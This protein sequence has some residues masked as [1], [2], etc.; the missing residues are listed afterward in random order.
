MPLA[1]VQALALDAAHCGVGFAEAEVASQVCEAA[2]VWKK[3]A[4][5][6]LHGAERPTARLLRDH[7]DAAEFLPVDLSP[8]VAALRRA[9]ARA[10]AWRGAARAT[11]KVAMLR[12]QSALGGASSSAAAASEDT[13]GASGAMDAGGRSSR[14]A[15][16]STA[17]SALLARQMQN[18]DS[19]GGNDG[20][21][22]GGGSSGSGTS[23]LV[24]RGIGGLSQDAVSTGQFDGAIALTTVEELLRAGRG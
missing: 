22:G 1:H 18:G 16:A 21:S 3:R 13:S 9:V 12:T 4:E 24:R 2:L 5:Q 11:L 8:E 15:A 10:D 23:G 19:G 20:G 14:R 7:A 17:K 6:L